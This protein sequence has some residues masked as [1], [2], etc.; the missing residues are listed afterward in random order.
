[1][2]KTKKTKK[3]NKEE[4][5][6][7]LPHKSFSL[8]V[9][10]EGRINYRAYNNAYSRWDAP[11]TVLVA[12]IPDESNLEIARNEHWYRIPV[13][14]APS[15]IEHVKTL[16]FYQPKIFK[17]EKWQVQ[18]YAPVKETVIRRRKE[19]LPAE[20]DHPRADED[21]Y[22][23]ILDKLEQLAQPIISR[24]GRR[25]TFIPTTEAKFRNAR[26]INDLF[27]DSPLEDKMHEGL[28]SQQIYPE[29]Q[30]FVEKKPV[31]YRLDFAIACRNG[32][33]N[34]EC[35]GDTYHTAPEAIAY[36][37]ERNNILTSQGWT[38]L[39][40][41]SKDINQRLNH[42]INLIK[43]TINRLDKLPEQ[44]PN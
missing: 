28:K 37:R 43:T 24:T 40:F 31:C 30:F 19:I 44:N 23:L 42:S 13:K 1:M 18:Y 2:K 34:I 33:L 27:A 39:R 5:L 41:G 38:V 32:Q 16:A 36:D 26:E 12:I 25:I 9:K 20:A 4:V 3:A 14:S 22:Q 8:L 10:D 7:E 15:N 35:D 17:E 21:Y 29:R 11:K 6:Y